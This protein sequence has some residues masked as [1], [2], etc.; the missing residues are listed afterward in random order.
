MER[1][2]LI[3]TANNEVQAM[4]P[5]LGSGIQEEFDIEKLRSQVVLMADADV[6][7]QHIRTL[8]SLFRASARP[9]LEGDMRT[10]RSHRFTRS[11]RARNWS[12]RSRIGNVTRSPTWFASKEVSEG[13]SSVAG[14]AR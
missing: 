11:G 1:A 12:T 13:R 3:D 9:L 7:G 10:W 4:I 2:R 5:A 14:P 8:P 6:D